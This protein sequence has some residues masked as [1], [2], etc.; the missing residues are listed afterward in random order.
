M[1]GTRKLKTYRPNFILRI[2]GSNRWSVY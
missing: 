2:I 1:G